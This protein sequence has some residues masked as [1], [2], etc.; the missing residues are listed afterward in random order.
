MYI[1]AFVV[2]SQCGL[3]EH[4]P[5]PL[6]PKDGRASGPA[7]VFTDEVFDKLQK[8]TDKAIFIC[9][10]NYNANGASFALQ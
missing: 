4:A 3:L 8:E 7:G 10:Q 6:E 9:Y 2:A 1:D 5:T